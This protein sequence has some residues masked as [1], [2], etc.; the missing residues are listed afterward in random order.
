MG[1]PQLASRLILP[2]VLIM[3][4]RP[5]EKGPHPPTQSRPKPSQLKA[6]TPSRPRQRGRTP[7][8]TW[9]STPRHVRVRQAQFKPLH[10][11]PLLRPAGH[12]TEIV[13]LSF[14]P[15]S[16][17]IATG[18]MDNTAKV[19]WGRK[20]KGIGSA[21]GEQHHTH[22][23]QWTLEGEPA[24]ACHQRWTLAKLAWLGECQRCKP[25]AG[26]SPGGGFQGLCIC[27]SV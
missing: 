13:C 11:C 10:P 25:H 22:I 2:L 16:T 1:S 9:P 15:Q 19:G 4:I 20:G 3:S 6:P 8:L 24:W 17:T 27:A 18:S 26:G 5:Q 14:N 21:G 12:D 23:A 7:A